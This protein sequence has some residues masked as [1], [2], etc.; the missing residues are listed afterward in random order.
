[1]QKSKFSPSKFVAVLLAALFLFPACYRPH[2]VIP[3]PITTPQ[4]LQYANDHALVEGIFDH[5]QGLEHVI[6]LTKTDHEFESTGCATL[7]RSGNSTTI[8][9]GTKNCLCNKHGRYRRGKIIINATGAYKDSGSA[10]VTTF[11]GYHENDCKVEGTKAVTNMGFDSSGKAYLKIVISATVTKNDGKVITVQW[12]RIRTSA[13]NF[14]PRIP[15]TTSH[16]FRSTGKGTT[17]GSWGYIESEIP[18]AAPLYSYSNSH[19]IYA[20]F[21]VYKMPD[22]AT[23]TLKYS[24][25][26]D[27]SGDDDA[28]V[29]G[30]DGKSKYITLP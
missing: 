21:V 23:C 16:Y 2:E 7:T 4:Y 10:Y 29:V 8:D 3:Q 5:L 24:D 12:T 20:G 26:K 15:I 17:S 1:M 27:P 18:A 22:G 19:Y 9:Y 11:D 14:I 30:P 6:S 28:E 25:D 13:E